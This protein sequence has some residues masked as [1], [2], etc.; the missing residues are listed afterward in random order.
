MQNVSGAYSLICKEHDLTKLK[1]WFL[2]FMLQTYNKQYTC[3]IWLLLKSAFF[4][5]PSWYSV[6]SYSAHLW[7]YMFGKQNGKVTGTFWSLEQPKN[8]AVDPFRIAVLLV[9]FLVLVLLVLCS[10]LISSWNECVGI[11]EHKD[12]SQFSLPNVTM[13]E[14]A[15]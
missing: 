9:F 15:T 2:F 11:N 12:L 5:W 10:K 7:S 6:G 1:F 14:L 8:I 3:S 13:D 4:I